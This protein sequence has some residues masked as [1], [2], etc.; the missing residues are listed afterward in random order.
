MIPFN[1]SFSGFREVDYVKK[2]IESGM[3]L[4]GDGAWTRRCSEWLVSQLGV[5]H[6]LLNHSATASLELAAMAMNLKPGDEIIMPSYTFVSTANAVVLRGGIPVFVDVRS[7]TLNINEKL[8]S[9]AITG[10]TKAIIPVHYA[11]VPCEMDEIM[12]IS[13]IHDLTVIEDAAQGIMS[14]YKGKALG[15][16]GHMGALSFHATKNISCGEGGA[17]LT[18]NSAFAES[19]EIIREKGTDRSKFFR[20]EVD[21]YTWVNKG[22]SYLPSELNASYLL[23]QF[24]CSN[25]ITAMRMHV[26]KRYHE[27]LK[28]FEDAGLLSRPIIPKDCIH[29]AHIYYF[30]LSNPDLRSGFLREIKKKGVECVFH[31]VPLHSSVMGR[32][33]CVIASDMSITNRVSNSIVRLPIWPGIEENLDFI[34]DKVSSVLESLTK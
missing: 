17:F 22:S 31:Y 6:A 23:A 9:G 24:E 20:G 29:N 21:K 10:R 18:N 15:T 13:A 8:I 1:K 5:K 27:F 3:P 12:R 32:E 30:T 11:G 2:A 25:I 26:W 4:S 33:N 7:D 16:I 19:A 34:E 14:T 28:P